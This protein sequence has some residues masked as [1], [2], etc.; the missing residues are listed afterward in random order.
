MKFILLKAQHTFQVMQ[1]VRKLVQKEKRR[2]RTLNV[3]LPHVI[4]DAKDVES[5]FVGNFHVKLPRQSSRS[6][7]VVF[8]SVEEKIQN[9]KLAKAKTVDGKRVIIQ[10]L[11]PLV[12]N[13]KTKKKKK[14]IF[15]PEVKTDIKVTQT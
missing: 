6:C 2:E 9:Y 10:T 7:H 8:P 11:Q 1:K 14:K 12:L 3:C 15:I 4:K 5:L 13:K